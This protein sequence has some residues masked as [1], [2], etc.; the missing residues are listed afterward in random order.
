M[1]VAFIDEEKYN[2]KW[3]K[4]LWYMPDY[5]S[6]G[7]RLEIVWKPEWEEF[8]VKIADAIIN[9]SLA[10]FAHKPWVIYDC[11]K[12]IRVV[13]RPMSEDEEIC[14]GGGEVQRKGKWGVQPPTRLRLRH[15]VGE[16]ASDGGAI[17]WW[18]SELEM[19]AKVRTS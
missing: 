17:W 7:S 4:E 14:Q 12:L 1:N 6:A 8:R 2:K 5:Y 13:L 3:V 11:E 19:V 16:I 15:L 9:K 10:T 18:R